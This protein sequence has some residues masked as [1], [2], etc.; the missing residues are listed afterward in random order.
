MTVLGQPSKNYTLSHLCRDIEE[1]LQASDCA[2]E[3]ASHLVLQGVQAEEGLCL[4]PVPKQVGIL[5]ACVALLFAHAR[6]K[7]LSYELKR[8]HD[9]II[10]T[11]S[12]LYL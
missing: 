7:C 11:S 2:L 4:Q 5:V 8:H 9:A 10:S 3:E 12:N 1:T 6:Y